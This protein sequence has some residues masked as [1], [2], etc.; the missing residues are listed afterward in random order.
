MDLLAIV[1][2]A[3]EAPPPSPQR[4]AW[5]LVLQFLGGLL[6]FA[7]AAVLLWKIA[8][9]H[10]DRYLRSLMG[11][12]QGI[13]TEVANIGA[14]V[15]EAT[16]GVNLSDSFD[17]IRRQIGRVNRRLQEVDGRQRITHS[18][19]SQHV[20]ESRL[21]AEALRAQGI[22][23]GVSRDWPEGQDLTE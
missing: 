20:R 4:A 6:T 7:A 8:R 2:W 9:P 5:E 23:L 13:S 19:L 16:G 15:D 10:V 3:A 21:S 18:I 17:D 11:S 14:K 12:V 22:N 1:R